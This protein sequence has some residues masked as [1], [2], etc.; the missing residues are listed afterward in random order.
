MNNSYRKLFDSV[1]SGK[2]D[3]ETVLIEN[4]RHGTNY[5]VYDLLYEYKDI[6]AIGELNKKNKD[7]NSYD[8]FLIISKKQ[9][10]YKKANKSSMMFVVSHK[11]GSLYRAIAVFENY[12]LNLTKIESRRMYDKPFEYIFY[13]DF[14]YS[15]NHQNRIDEIIAVYKENTQYLRIIGYYKSTNL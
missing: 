9:I 15:K 13:V 14:E 12:E 3:T 6:Y 4:S 10:S 1:H 8:R 7:D 2:S 11:P 5:E